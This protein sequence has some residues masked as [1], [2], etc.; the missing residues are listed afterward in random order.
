MILSII[1]P[2]YNVEKYIYECLESIIS[3]DVN[4]NEYEVICIDDCGTD[5]SMRIVNQFV[6]VHSSF[7]IIKIKH[8][9]NKGLSEARNTGIQNAKGKYILFLDSDDYLKSFSL[10]KCLNILK[11]DSV[12]I[13][14]FNYEEFFETNLNISTDNSSLAFENMEY[15]NGQDY[16]L[17]MINENSYVPMVWT[18]IYSVEFLR[19]NNLKFTP[20]LISEDEDFTPKVLMK[21]GKIIQINEVV[22]MYRRRDNSITTLFQ[23]K[24]NW[25]DSYI[26]I[27]KEMYELSNQYLRCKKVLRKRASQL[28]TSLIKNIVKYNISEENKNTIINIVKD[29]KMCLFSIKSLNAIEIL[30]GILM[31]FPNGFIFFYSI[32]SRFLNSK[33]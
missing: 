22:Y 29:E 1:I 2:I 21:C 19:K 25:V 15:R 27:I 3:Q 24:I 23:K 11:N 30:E 7:N 16:F 14:A 4:K 10:N 17:R 33:S 18:R 13:L 5:N 28:N 31:L 9:I 6:D 12:D 26:Y 8:E 32:L 20:G